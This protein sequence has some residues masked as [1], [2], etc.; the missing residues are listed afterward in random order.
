MSNQIQ[1]YR[2][3]LRQPFISY[4]P[5]RCAVLLNLIPAKN[6][7]LGTEIHF[8][9][10]AAVA[11]VARTGFEPAAFAVKGRRPKPLDDRAKRF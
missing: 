3:A 8:E 9:S 2:Q 7:A 1:V 5:V 10:V 6:V 4:S 11:K